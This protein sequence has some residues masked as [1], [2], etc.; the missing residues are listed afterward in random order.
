MLFLILHLAACGEPKPLTCDGEVKVTVDDGDLDTIVRKDVALTGTA[1]HSG[2]FA[3][4]KVLVGGIAAEKTGFNFDAW[5]VTVPL[6][7]LVASAEAEDTDAAKGEATLEV[8]A[9]DACDTTYAASPVTLTV[10]LSP[11]VVVAQGQLRLT[12]S[13][14]P[15]Q[16]YLPA[17][18][19]ELAAVEVCAPADAVDV[20]VSLQSSQGAFVGTLANDVMVLT[21]GTCFATQ[22]A[23]AAVATAF[24]APTASSFTAFVS[25]TGG[26]AS[27]SEQIDVAAA[28]S[29][30]PSNSDMSAGQT[31][32][33]QLFSDGLVSNCTAY[34]ADPA[35][36]AVYLDGDTAK[37]LYDGE[38]V[39]DTVIGTDHTITV[40]ATGAAAATVSVVCCDV[41]D[42][43]SSAATFALAG[44]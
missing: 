29:I 30:V 32:I 1:A 44:T 16:G 24:F 31:L 6:D 9:M 3:I 39:G 35:S 18:G 26:G 21:A 7:V 10:D 2:G 36:L 13:D 22:D 11:D 37:T 28:P 4:H 27:A 15:G 38:N 25:A 8:E 20:E 5:T 41:F 33:A 19:S 23:D 17:D 43:C 42:Q 34:G 40:A 12:V 14:M